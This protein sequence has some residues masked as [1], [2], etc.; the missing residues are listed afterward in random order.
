MKKKTF[1]FVTAFRNHAPHDTRCIGFYPSRKQ[2]RYP[3]KHSWDSI[4]EMGYYKYV[5][6]EEFGFGWYP[7]SGKKEEWYQL[8]NRKVTKIPK[9]EH[10]ERVGSFGIG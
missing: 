8:K 3:I 1:F 7:Y 6:I 10:Y 4:C 5:I 2:A 9:P